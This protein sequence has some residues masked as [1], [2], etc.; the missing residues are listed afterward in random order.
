M[1]WRWKW[2][3]GR[4]MNSEVWHAICVVEMELLESAQRLMQTTV[5]I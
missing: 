3:N 5:Y 2:L 4:S 1:Q